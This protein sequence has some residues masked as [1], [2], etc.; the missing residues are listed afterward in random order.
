MRFRSAWLVLPVGS[1]PLCILNPS[2]ISRQPRPEASS[3]ARRKTMS[4]HGCR[5]FCL[6]ATSVFLGLIGL[7]NA[8]A[9]NTGPMVVSYNVL[10]G[11]KSF[12]MLTSTRNRLPWTIKDAGGN[13]LSG[14]SGF[15]RTINVLCGD[16]N[17]DGVVNSADLTLVNN[18]RAQP[19]NIFA[20]INGDRVVNST[21]V[22]IVRSRLGTSLCQ[23]EAVPGGSNLSNSVP[24]SGTPVTQAGSFMVSAGMDCTITNPWVAASNSFWLTV[25]GGAPGDASIGPPVTFKAPSNAQ[26]SSRQGTIWGTRGAGLSVGF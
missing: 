8:A 12:N 13:A 2:S 15:S 24:A 5:L 6:S 17:D 9:G 14:G 4:A 22:T 25:T 10:F 26:S 11:T 19:Y 16:F 3:L 23:I 21:D 20:D 7:T 1:S 18:A